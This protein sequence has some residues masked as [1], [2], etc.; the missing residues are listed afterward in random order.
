[1]R[2]FEAYQTV[3]ASSL[4]ALKAEIN[5][6]L[7]DARSGRVSAVDVHAIK[8]KGRAALQSKGSV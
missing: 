4:A 7:A 1:L 8:T 6:G 5:Q 2:L 3:H